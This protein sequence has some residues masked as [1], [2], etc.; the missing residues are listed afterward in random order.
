[1]RIAVLV[2]VF[3]GISY[4]T[5]AESVASGLQMVGHDVNLTR[6]YFNYG[7]SR[8]YAW[9]IYDAVILVDVPRRMIVHEA[10]AISTQAPAVVY[11]I[12]EGRL[13]G[14]DYTGIMVPHA[15]VAISKY[16]YEM[17]KLSNV[18]N[19][20]GYVHHM[21]PP[22]IY[23][24][25]MGIKEVRK[26]RYFLY[27]GGSWRRKS[28][29]DIVA[30][31][32]YLFHTEPLMRRFKLFIVSDRVPNKYGLTEADLRMF[33]IYRLSYPMDRATLIRLISG[34]YAVLLP[35]KIEGFGMPVIEAPALGTPV[36]TLDCPP[37]NEVELPS[38]I[39]VP[40]RCFAGQEQYDPAGPDIYFKPHVFDRRDLAE[41]LFTTASMEPEEIEKLAVE[42]MKAAL[43]KYPPTRYEEILKVAGLLT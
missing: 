32:V 30:A 38:I 41:V 28:L 1:M 26:Q 5:V 29:D 18:P 3:A 8:Q 7:M 10:G 21:V 19:V 40:A 34:A 2:N 6:L 39:K 35:S 31:W 17:L 23:N 25:A 37:M 24:Y 36:I 9:S 11:G 14:Q 20:V 16:A 33:N 13:V 12:T 43:E 42:G 27:Y 15:V 4:K 22:D